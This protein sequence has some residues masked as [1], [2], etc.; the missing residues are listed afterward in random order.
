MKLGF[1]GPELS[2]DQT[3]PDDVLI[4]REGEVLLA[5]DPATAEQVE[6][7]TLVFDPRR[8]RLTLA[9]DHVAQSL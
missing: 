2:L 6:G 7:R 4:E 9:A 1:R 8:L 3:R 5:V